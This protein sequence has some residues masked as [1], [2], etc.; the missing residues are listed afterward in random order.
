MRS[1]VNQSAESEKLLF[2]EQKQQKR[3][4]SPHETSKDSKDALLLLPGP[5]LTLTRYNS[6]EEK[7][8][9]FG[10]KGQVSNT[11]DNGQD[12][13]AEDMRRQNLVA[14]EHFG[15]E[16]VKDNASVRRPAE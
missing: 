1:K 8:M 2:E 6:N 14:S 3:S 16:E 12:S 11:F 15:Q 4:N 13:D 5:K 7:S 10:R 9:T